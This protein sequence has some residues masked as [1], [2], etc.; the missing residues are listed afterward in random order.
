MYIPFLM[1]AGVTLFASAL[2]TAVADAG[3]ALPPGAAVCLSAGVS[4]FFVA[5]AAEPIRYGGPWRDIV[6]W[7]PAGVLLP[8]ALVPL[9]VLW[10]S[11]AV[12]SAS[13]VVVALLLA[14]TEVNERRMRA[15]QDR[16]RVDP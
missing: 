11:E 15:G 7:G 3:H 1:V 5:S 4:L 9:A 6:I 12:V 13:V 8:W 10:P 2:G 14:L 16:L